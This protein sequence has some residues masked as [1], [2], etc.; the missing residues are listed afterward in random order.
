MNDY[1]NRWGQSFI[2]ADPISI[3]NAEKAYEKAVND[4]KLSIPT[5][6]EE[7]LKAYDPNEPIN[8]NFEVVES[9]LLNKKLKMYRDVVDMTLRLDPKEYIPLLGDLWNDINSSVKLLMTKKS[10][11]FLFIKLHPAFLADHWIVPVRVDSFYRDDIYAITEIEFVRLVMIFNQA[12]VNFDWETRFHQHKFLPHL[13]M[14][15]NKMGVHYLS[16]GFANHNNFIN[17]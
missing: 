16:Q 2:A 5:S 7:R 13:L 6:Y 1:L 9:P 4:S 3:K 8:F 15:I 12:L 10:W 14:T 17:T 11:I